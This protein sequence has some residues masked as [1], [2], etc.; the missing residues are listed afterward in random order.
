MGDG[1]PQPDSTTGT[2]FDADLA[3]SFDPAADK[4]TATVPANLI[5]AGGISGLALES[6]RELLASATDA[7]EGRCTFSVGT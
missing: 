6:A 5:G 2:S 1:H 3:G 7:A 4:V